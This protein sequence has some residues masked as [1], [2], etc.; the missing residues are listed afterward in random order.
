MDTQPA[1]NPRTFSHDTYTTYHNPVHFNSC[2]RQAYFLNQAPF[3]P[4]PLP[5]TY[6]AMNTMATTFATPPAF[7]GSASQY[8]QPSVP[9][10]GPSTRSRKRK[11]DSQENERL[12]KRLG[13]LNL[14]KGGQK[15]YIPVESPAESPHLQP[16]T[17]STTSG[18]P[19]PH[20]PDDDSMRLDDTSHKVYIYNLDDEL[21]SSDSESVCSETDNSYRLA[22]LT[23]IDKHMKLNRIP[24]SVFAN[25]D[26]EI[27]GTNIN[28]MQMV[29]YSDPSSLTVEDPEKDGVRRAIIEARKRLREKQSSGSAGEDTGSGQSTPV[30]RS[31]TAGDA[32]LDPNEM[33]LD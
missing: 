13:Q 14:E 4:Q 24:Q 5:Q 32:Y 26:G 17:S 9:S 33:E 22:F 31:P 2:A 18:N 20:I 28:D 10:L 21:S 15:L 12:S 19:L 3:I 27:A 30:T 8:E 29:L 1:S 23:D 6:H 25:N 7:P 11:A 16:T